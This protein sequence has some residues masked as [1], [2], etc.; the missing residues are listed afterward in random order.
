MNAYQRWHTTRKQGI[1]PS[2]VLRGLNQEW[3]FYRTCWRAGRPKGHWAGR[4]KSTECEIQALLK[5]MELITH[6]SPEVAQLELRAWGEK[7]RTPEH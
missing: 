7:R 4:H 1:P 5:A 3:A 2:D 6:Y